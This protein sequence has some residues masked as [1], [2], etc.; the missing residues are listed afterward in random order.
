MFLIFLF[1]TQICFSQFIP[2]KATLTASKDSI[3]SDETFTVTYSLTGVQGHVYI[4]VQYGYFET[5]G[6]DRWNGEIKPGETK[7]VSFT[8]KLKENVKESIQRKIPLEVGFSYHPFGNK[9]LRAHPEGVIITIIDYKQ[10]RS[11]FNK[12]R[13]G[14]IKNH[15]FDLYPT[16]LDS[17][18]PSILKQKVSPDTSAQPQQ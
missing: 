7:K 4:G 9:I 14:K 6:K 12:N 15:V 2:H 17:N 18:L 3:M 16:L 10:L 8:V 13:L 5:I 1:T 11:K